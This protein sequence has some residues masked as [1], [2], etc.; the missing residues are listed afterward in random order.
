MR[1]API[2]ADE[3]Q[4]LAALQRYAIL[5]SDPENAFDDVVRLAKR[6]F[7][8]PVALIALVDQDRLWFKS[9]DGR[10]VKEIP[11]DL[12]FCSYTILSDDILVI[13][14]ATRDELYR[15]N[16]RV[17]GE[18]NIRFYAG[19][20]II[21]KEGHRI[22]T[23]CLLDFKPRDGFSD[24]DAVLLRDLA[25]IA[26]SQI[27]MRAKI[28][29]AAEQARQ[30]VDVREQLAFAEA[31]VR[32]F[33]EYAPVSVAM[34]DN[35]MRYVISSDS[36]QETFGQ[37]GNDCIGKRHSDLMPFLPKEWLAQHQACL[38]G[39]EIDVAED[40]LKL[41]DGRELWLRRILRPWRTADGSIGGIIVFNENITEQRAIQQQLV[42]AQKMESVGQLTGGMAHDFNNLLNIVLGNLQ[43]LERAVGNDAKA[44]Q[45]IASAIDA[46]DKG[47][48]LNRRLLTFARRQ[49]LEK[50]A[51][52][53]AD[54]I[55]GLSSLLK[56]T[57]G[58]NIDLDC[59][60]EDSVDNILT[61]PNQ[62][63][64]AIVNLA[65]NAR[66]AMPAGGRLKI[67]SR[68]QY[69]DKQAVK[70]ENGTEPGDYVCISVTDTGTGIFAE[71]L[72]HVV[73][74]FF[75]TK[76]TTK[77]TGLGLSIVYGLLKQSGG[78][79]RISSEVGSGTTVRLYFPVYRGAACA[80]PSGAGAPGQSIEGSGTVLLVEDRDDVREIASDM[81]GD[82]GYD[83]VSAADGK[84]AIDILKS[85]QTV[86]L[87]FTDIIMPG[88]VDGTEVARMA[89]E[90]RPG[91]PVVFSSGYAEA[92]VLRRGDIDVSSNLITKPYRREELGR[93]LHE[94]RQSSAHAADD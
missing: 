15:D 57:M 10:D 22:G 29:E 35:Q 80:V 44:R 77:G 64:S 74:P 84:S 17:K 70:R 51:F 73:E 79:M 67:E 14:D 21:T 48:D 90:L 50:K 91:L 60:F 49:N 81:L 39:E 76:G 2:P 3:K 42:Q 37:I 28:N 86:D 65:L 46:V 30:N 52:K 55:R 53:P 71:D 61:D 54:S 16:P 89:R 68:L 93:M 9:I 58:E 56:H 26:M 19:A 87:V 1:A 36:W 12:A 7:D 31:Q 11:R 83:V 41:P 6:L 13:P 34:F 47:V 82:L 62:F 27:E 23:F 32:Y 72:P 43:L 75:T 88:G 4:R 69:L 18:P 25:R 20:P 40:R 63:E 8:V 59:R 66:D 33:F 5:D 85:P 92:S 78:F 24:T 45:R 38:A 94:A